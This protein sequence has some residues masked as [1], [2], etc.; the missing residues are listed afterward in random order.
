MLPTA[1]P[2]GFVNIAGD[3]GCYKIVTDPKS[4]EDAKT[5]CAQFGSSLVAIRSQGQQLAISNYIKRYLREYS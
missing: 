5:N 1:C 4:W 3:T 2:N